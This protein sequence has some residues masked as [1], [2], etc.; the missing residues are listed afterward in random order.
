[1]FITNDMAKALDAMVQLA[2]SNNVPEEQYEEPL[3]VL[4]RYKNSLIRHSKM[5]AH[6]DGHKER[7]ALTSVEGM[8]CIYPNYEDAKDGRTKNERVIPVYVTIEKAAK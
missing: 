5:Y 3:Q 6:I 8:L 4:R 2:K 7:Y 1:M